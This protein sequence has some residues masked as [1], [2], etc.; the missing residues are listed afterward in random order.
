MQ[1][2]AATSLERH[3]CEL[4]CEAV[5]CLSDGGGNLIKPEIQIECTFLPLHKRSEGGPIIIA[6]PPMPISRVLWI[7]NR[8]LSLF[9]DVPDGMEGH[10]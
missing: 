3:W 5:V 1:A 6:S 10:I 4:E 2:Q 7:I 9:P 8:V